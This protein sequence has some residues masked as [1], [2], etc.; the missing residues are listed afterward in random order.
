[1]FG[2]TWG[3]IAEIAEGSGAPVD[4]VALS[5]IVAC[6][7]LIGGKRRVSPW[8]GWSEPCIVWAACVGDPSSNK[9]P[10]IDATTGPFR[11]IE[12]DHAASHDERLRQ[13]EA[14]V[15]R[16]KAEQAVWVESVKQATKDNAGTPSKPID[17]VIPD[18]PVRRRLMVMDATPEAVGAILSGNPS[19]TLHLRDELAGWLLSFDRY[20]PGGREFWLEAYGGR[21]HVIDRKGSK[22]P[23]RIPFN[24]VSVLGGIQPEKLSECLLSGSDDGLVARFLWAWPRPNQFRRPRSVADI[25]K[26]ESIY[27]RLDGLSW[28]VANDGSNAP[29][30]LELD[31]KAVDLFEEWGRDNDKGMDDAGALYKGF[32]GKLKGL[33]LRLALT[34]ELSRWA[35]SGFGQEPRS[36]SV[37]TLGATI[38]FVES[39]A[40]P[41]A[42]RV[43][44]DAALPVV[45]RNAA[46]LARYIIKHGLRV[47]N[48]RDVHKKYG[49][50]GLKDTGA[51]S[52]ALAALEDADWLRNVGKRA[53]ETAGRPKADYAVNPA[54]HGRGG[55]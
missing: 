26:L 46:T 2:T 49:L 21:A 23:L 54:V 53:G 6:A 41:T 4:Y 50:P 38:E 19:G 15:E 36:I 1:M 30:T 25:Y 13:W 40:K 44:G 32:L 55:A 48:A 52:E 3:L 33:V 9:S 17:A 45:D 35:S 14:T 24:G 18:E 39:Y 28:D 29:V 7:S 12:T 8:G 22:G 10:A 43:F 11:M 16:A 27:R 51:V 47:V 31:P 5:Y 20:S 34:A 37:A 42:L